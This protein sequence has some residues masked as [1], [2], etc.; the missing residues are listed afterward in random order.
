MRR[1]ETNA[2][3]A[4]GYTLIELLV[5]MAIIGLL[6]GLLL[7]AIQKIREAGPRLSV[8]AEIGE[9]EKAIESFKSSY[10]VK[11]IPT[12]FILAEDYNS[13]TIPGFGPAQYAALRDSKQYYSK[14]WP[15]GL[16]NGRPPMPSTGSLQYPYIVLDGNQLLVFLLGGIPP[17]TNFLPI[18]FSAGWQGN[19]SGFRNSPTNPFNYNGMT[20]VS[21]SPATGETAKGPHFNFKLDR[22]DSLGHYHDIYWDGQNTGANVYFYFSAKEGNDYNYFGGYNAVAT[23]I[24]ATGGYGGMEPL[25]G[26]DGKYMYQDKY[27]IISA[28]RDHV[29]GAG[30]I[31]GNSATYWPG[32]Y[33]KGREGGGDDQTNFAQ[34]LLG[35]DE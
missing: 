21:S 16:V 4:A 10:D 34:Y 2:R 19:R 26:Q 27:Q 33:A 18:G 29:P 14:I 6:I 20:G 24:T 7:P 30:S 12:A 9:L 31:R 3:P 11:Y 22:L 35:G 17:Q 25:I 8:K 23:G 1:S 5:V 28:G 15:K 32:L 13:T